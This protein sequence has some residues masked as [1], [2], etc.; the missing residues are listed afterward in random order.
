MFESVRSCSSAAGKPNS[1]SGVLTDNAGLVS[2]AAATPIPGTSLATGVSYVGAPAAQQAF[3]FVVS[4]GVAGCPTGAP[5]NT[6]VLVSNGT[7]TPVNALSVTLNA[8]VWGPPDVFN[9]PFTRVDFYV[10]SGG[11]LVN[12]G[13]ATA[14][15]L[16]DNGALLFGRRYR[17][18]FAFTPGTTFPA[19]AL[20][21]HAVGANALGD[22][23][24]TLG[25]A[26]VTVTAP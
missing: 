15:T 2:A 24:S 8:D 10:V 23:L 22:A 1:L 3:A 18:S 13:S 7:G 16:V 14:S 6:P 26:N 9:A 19:G 11:N 25:N 12:V 5:V 20:T 17:Y 4:N 21:I